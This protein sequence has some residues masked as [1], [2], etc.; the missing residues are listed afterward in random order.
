MTDN[1]VNYVTNCTEI[2][3]DKLKEHK[4]ELEEE[5]Q[6]LL[7]DRDSNEKLRANVAD[8]KK[9]VT[10]VEGQL[11]SITGMK[12]ELKSYVGE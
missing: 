12:E 9:K 4:V 11:G 2:Y 1:V 10:I 7:D 3:R 6:K 5:Y 8:L